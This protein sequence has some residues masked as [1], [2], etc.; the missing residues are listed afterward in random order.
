MH[1]MRIGP[2]GAERPAVRAG[3]DAYIDVGDLVGDF[4][5]SFF[6]AAARTFSATPSPS[7][8]PPGR[9]LRSRGNASGH[10][11]LDHS[12]SCASA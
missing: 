6:A 8:P 12:R 2:P 7:A 9:R 11:S 1:L 10:P 5:G 3:N 4:D